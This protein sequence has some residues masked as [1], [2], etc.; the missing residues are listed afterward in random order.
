[1]ASSLRALRPT[2]A[3]LRLGESVLAP[4]ELGQLLRAM[5]S[6]HRPLLCFRL[7]VESIGSATAG[8]LRAARQRHAAAG[9]LIDFADV[10]ARALPPTL[11][12]IGAA[13]DEVGFDLPLALAVEG[14][15]LVFGDAGRAA[16]FVAEALDAGFPTPLLA[17]DG[18]AESAMADDLAAAAAPAKEHGLGW[19]LALGP[20]PGSD[21]PPLLATLAQ[22]EAGPVAVRSAGWGPARLPERLE[23]AL[24]WI[25]SSGRELPE[26]REALARAG[27]AVVEVPLR[28]LAD[29]RG[30]RAEAFAYFAAEA[31]LSAWDV[32]QTGPRAAAALLAAW[33]E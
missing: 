29:A 31:A 11:A 9:L 17:I 23:G 32:E 6:L 4:L 33:K 12:A 8:V 26:E 19:A 22:R 1:V 16:G 30:P 21:L 7:P 14:T 13:G 18:P 3:A 20:E 25:V 15:P 28:E 5:A 24:P 10:P 2:A 27:A